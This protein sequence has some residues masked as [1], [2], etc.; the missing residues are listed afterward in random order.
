MA[1][2]H[3]HAR[4]RDLTVTT[5]HRTCLRR[6]QSG[7]SAGDLSEC[8]G[9][10]YLHDLIRDDEKTGLPVLSEDG[11]RLLEAHDRL[12]ETRRVEQL[13]ATARRT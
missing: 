6:L 3:L 10:L 9:A 4:P 2:D 8:L 11:R 12:V 7:E 5:A 13:A 1:V